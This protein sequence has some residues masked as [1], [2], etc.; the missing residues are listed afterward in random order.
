MLTTPLFRPWR[1]LW[2]AHLADAARQLDDLAR[3]RR[4]GRQTPPLIRDF[5]DV[6][7]ILRVLHFAEGRVASS[8]FVKQRIEPLL[9]A[10]V[11]PRWLLL[12]AALDHAANSGDLHLSALVLRSQIE[13]LDA[14]RVAATVLSAQEE[15]S[16]DGDLM[17]EPIR[18]LLS[19]V[20]PRLQTK[21][22][23]HLVEQ[24]SDAVVAAERPETLQRAFDRLSE[25]V[26]PNYGSHLLS[27]RPQCIKAA[28]VLVESFVA[29]Y[30]NFFSLP[31]AREEDDSCPEPTPSVRTDSKDPF[32]ILVDETLPALKAALPSVDESAWDNVTE[33][34]RQCAGSE[35]N[36]AFPDG[37]PT[38]V[39]AIAELRANAVPSD[40]WPAALKTLAGQNRYALLVAQEDQ[41][42]KDASRLSVGGD[43]C[44]EKDRVS[45]LASGLSFTINVTEYKLNSLAHQASRLINSE[46]VLGAVLAIRSMLEHHALAIELGQKLQVLWGRA[47]KSAAN[48]S[49]VT[50]A[51]GEVEKQMARVLAGSSEP[52]AASSSWRALWSETVRKPYNVLGPVRALDAIQPGCLKWYGLLSH[53]VHGTVATGGDLL[54]G[55][56]AEWKADHRPLAAKLVQFLADVCRFDAMLD[57]QATLISITHRLEIVR[58][59]PRQAAERIK[60]MRLLDGQKLKS[61]RDIFGSGTANDPFHFRDGLLYHEAYHQYLT[62]EGISAGSRTLAHLGSGIG[63]RVAAEDGR[64][65]YFL[66]DQLRV[67]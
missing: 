42:A 49:K 22:G 54:G 20:L 31:W 50:E 39:E 33:S 9:K 46:N 27:V 14:L 3:Q 59:D 56:G 4:N 34:F 51:L 28:E 58:L 53:I 8:E 40:A 64:I 52:S 45:V 62:Q 25:Y 16:W 23:E 63:D 44:D 32:L 21:N 36:W 35:K 17:A 11:W 30:E 55:G 60:A 48:A 5:S 43:S 67:Q 37:L 61:G 13:E 65:L 26:H 47:E 10:C 24:A 7:T 66:N 2:D 38:D 15:G 1:F 6:L 18:T 19:R 57:R 12:E 29:I 41:L